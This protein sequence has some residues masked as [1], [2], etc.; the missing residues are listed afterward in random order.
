MLKNVCR[1]SESSSRSMIPTSDRL[2]GS[3]MRPSRAGGLSTA[4]MPCSP[5]A[6]PITPGHRQCRPP[7][8]HANPSSHPT[9]PACTHGLLDTR[10]SPWQPPSAPRRGRWQPRFP[11]S[12]AGGGGLGPHRPARGA[13]AR[14]G[15]GLRR[16]PWGGGAG[17]GG[18]GG[19]ARRPGAGGGAPRGAAQREVSEPSVPVS[20]LCL[21]AQ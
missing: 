7:Q 1:S 12:P 17:G 9:P 15:G 8:P 19:A 5:L 20:F 16:R 18:G 6:N 14:R 4:M 11:A 21:S 3:D 2:C 13:V 10:S